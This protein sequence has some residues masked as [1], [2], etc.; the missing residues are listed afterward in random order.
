MSGEYDDLEE[1]NRFQPDEKIEK[2]VESIPLDLKEIEL[3]N[4]L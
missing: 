4:F 3:L 1:I 2:R